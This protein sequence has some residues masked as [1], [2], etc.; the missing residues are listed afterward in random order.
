MPCNPGVAPA[1]SAPLSLLAKSSEN[2]APRAGLDPAVSGDLPAPRG[3][4]SPR[5]RFRTA[6]GSK[7][8]EDDYVVVLGLSAGRMG[9]PSGMVD[10]PLLDLVLADSEPFPNAEECRLFYVAL[11]RAKRAVFLIAERTSPS[12]FVVELETGGYD[13]VNLGEN[14]RAIEP[15]P[16]CKEGK[17]VIRVGKN[18]P[19]VG[20]S[21]YP[22]CEH[23]EDT[24][25]I[26]RVGIIGD[27]SKC[28]NPECKDQM[29]ICPKCGRGWMRK[30]THRDGTGDFF[31]C[32][33]YPI[34]RH[35]EKT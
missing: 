2:L 3:R 28:T 31:G 26:C 25:P 29:R 11:T 1:R 27:Q 21:F 5:A 12:A 32:S 23:T 33:D 6:H 15:C 8:L 30:K 35:T 13:V 19:F 9:F 18:D 14:P 24:C 20:C 7:G 22:L 17:L 34:C 10:D 16:L 4:V